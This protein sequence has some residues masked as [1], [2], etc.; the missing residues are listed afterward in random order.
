MKCEKCGNEFPSISE[1]ALPLLCKDC[2]SKLTPEELET[3]R[4]LR[5]GQPRFHEFDYR[6]GFGTRAGAYLLDTLLLG[7]IL[8]IVCLCTG[9]F[10]DYIQILHEA[11]QNIRDSQISADQFLNDYRL[12]TVIISLIILIYWSLEILEGASIGKFFL[13]IQICDESRRIASTKQLI[14]RYIFKNLTIIVHFIAFITAIQILDSFPL[15]L[16]IIFDV[17][18][19]FV[20]TKRH[21]GLHDMIVKTAVFHK[22]DILNDNY[23]ENS[24]E[25]VS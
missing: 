11:N 14:E 21:Q 3:Y 5:I 4:N 1:F 6:I 15:V 12:T 16:G 8:F 18:C 22:N 7:I 23:I 24:F 17:S 25:V 19:L 13:G 10:S 2:F 9:I 20:F